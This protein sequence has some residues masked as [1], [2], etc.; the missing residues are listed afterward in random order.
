VQVERTGCGAK[1]AFKCPANGLVDVWLQLD[2]A[3]I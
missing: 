1:P 2:R 3:R